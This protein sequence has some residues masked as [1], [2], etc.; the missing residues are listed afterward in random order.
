MLCIE[1]LMFVSCIECL[2]VGWLL[3]SLAVSSAGCDQNNLSWREVLPRWRVRPFVTG[4][5]WPV[6]PT[7]S[8]GPPGDHII[9]LSPASPVHR[10]QTEVNNKNQ[11]A[12][13]RDTRISMRRGWSWATYSDYRERVWK[14]VRAQSGVKQCELTR[15]S[16]PPP[17]NLVRS[18]WQPSG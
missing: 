10:E 13:K 16:R 14:E 9:R 3:A 15:L 2:M 11:F 4:R 6:Y 8:S 5:I 12:W 18:D 17:G 7:H 1:I